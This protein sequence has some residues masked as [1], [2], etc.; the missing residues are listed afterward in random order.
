MIDLS[1]LL[2]HY[3]HQRRLDYNFAVVTSAEFN[4]AFDDLKEVALK[5]TICKMKDLIG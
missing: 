1:L 3:I 2:N 4:K 5:D